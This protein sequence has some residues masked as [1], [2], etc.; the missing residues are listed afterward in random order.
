M[1]FPLCKLCQIQVA[2]KLNSHIVPK[3]MSKNVFDIKG[4]KKTTFYL[5]KDR[6]PQPKQDTPKEDH[7]LCSNCEKRF[8]V[9]ET[10][11]STRISALHE[12]KAFPDRFF[13][14]KYDGIGIIECKDFNP[15]MFKFFIY[16]IIWRMSISKE[17]QSLKLQDDIEEN[18]RVFLDKHLKKKQGDLLDSLD[19]VSY[20]PEYEICMFKCVDKDS[21]GNMLSASNHDE[22]LYTFMLAQFCLFLSTDGSGLLKQ[23]LRFSNKQNKNVLIGA[24]SKQEWKS[25]F[26]ILLMKSVKHMGLNE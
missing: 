9:L 19:D 10:Y 11:F 13:Y 12:F 1:A 16:S 23:T 4:H 26:T 22:K 14:M 24:L 17:F 7:I 3:F 25:V 21:E 8:E 18:I 15:T 6:K 20:L 5:K 2:D